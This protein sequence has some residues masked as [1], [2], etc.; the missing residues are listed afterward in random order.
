[1]AIGLVGGLATQSLIA[2]YLGPAGRGE[3]G[4]WL[5]VATITAIFFTM[6]TDRAIQVQLISKRLSFAQAMSATILIACVGSLLAVL[7]LFLVSLTQWETVHNLIPS[8]IG[9]GLLVVPVISFATAVQLLLTGLRHFRAAAVL[10]LIRMISQLALVTLLVVGLNAGVEGA[11]LAFVTGGVLTSVSSLAY[12]SRIHGNV[13]ASVPWLAYQQVFSYALKYLPARLGH[14]VNANLVVIVLALIATKP[15]VG[16]FSLSIVLMGQFLIISEALNQAILPRLSEEVN[17]NVEL[18][19]RCCRSSLLGIMILLLFGTG[20]LSAAVPLL[21]SRQFQPI[22]PLLWILLPGIWLRGSVGA[23]RTYFVATHR[24]SIV[25]TSVSLE[26]GVTAVALSLLYSSAGL[27]GAAFAASL[28]NFSGALWLGLSFRRYTQLRFAENWIWNAVDSR[29]LKDRVVA[30][31][32]I[33]LARRTF[34]DASSAA[35]CTSRQIRRQVVIT[36]DSII[37][38]QPRSFFESELHRTEQAELIARESETFC[39]PKILRV[40]PQLGTIHFQRIQ[41]SRSLAS[42]LCEVSPSCADRFLVKAGQTLAEIHHRLPSTTELQIDLASEWIPSAKM[43]AVCI[44]G[45]FT[46]QNILITNPSDRLVVIDWV[47]SDLCGSE[48]TTGPW[49]FDVAWFIRSLL[50]VPPWFSLSIAHAADRAKV[51]ATAYCRFADHGANLE[52]LGAYL[53]AVAPSLC[54]PVEQRTSVRSLFR[55]QPPSHSSIQSI[56]CDMSSHS[57]KLAAA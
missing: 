35:L 51:F 13:I 38:K 52:E 18:V 15:E 32:G 56:A 17:G 45:D 54:R 27:A 16:L 3:Y 22:V 40:E 7:G 20:I 31:L 55:G 21:F 36:A 39:V 24:P 1:M 42:A 19:A 46:V 57:G 10:G 26:L 44:H 28:G 47:T 9:L 12:L 25:S 8:G 6:G 41:N 23:I 4:T 37:K 43:Q 53:S 14:V 29:C 2:R 49:A 11:F 5:A 48:A 50:G 30:L 34:W 33:P